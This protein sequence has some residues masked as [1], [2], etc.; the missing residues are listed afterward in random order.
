MEQCTYGT[1]ELGKL[2][3]IT[4]KFNDK[5]DQIKCLFAISIILMS[6]EQFFN[7]NLFSSRYTFQRLQAPVQ[8]GSMDSEGGVFSITFDMSGTRMIT[9]EAD[10]TI[11]VYREDDT[12]VSGQLK[13]YLI[14]E[15]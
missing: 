4:L 11:K 14:K 3:Q 8:P 5:V 6:Y 1:G 10:K 13:Y 12:A 2:L 7:V 15:K 9:T